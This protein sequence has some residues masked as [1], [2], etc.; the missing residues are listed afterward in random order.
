M[1]VRY[2]DGTVAIKNPPKHPQLPPFFPS[3]RPFPFVDTPFDIF[4]NG[5]F[6]DGT[7]RLIIQAWTKQGH[8]EYFYLQAD[9]DTID[10]MAERLGNDPSTKTGQTTGGKYFNATVRALLKS[11]TPL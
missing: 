9:A 1:K 11:K 4:V 5:P 8:F 6:P 2:P 3:A 7:E 10:N